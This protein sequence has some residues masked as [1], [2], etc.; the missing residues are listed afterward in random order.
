MNRT[1]NYQI[2]EKNEAIRDFLQ[3]KGYSRHIRTWIKQ[4][5]DSLILNGTPVL[6]YVELHQGDQLAVH[7]KEEESSEKIIPTPLPLHIVYEDEDILIINKEADTPVHPSMGNYEN[8]LA[9]AVAW[10]YA[11]QNKSF[12][13]R[14]INRLDRDT[15]GLLILAKNMLSGALLS[16]QMKQ[17]E[18]HRTYLSIVEGKIPEEG[19][20]S[21]PIARTCDSLIER[22]V[23]WEKGEYAVT[24]YKRLSSL[25]H[26]PVALASD[27][28]K[29]GLSLV[30]LQLE[31]GRTHQ[32]RVHMSYLGHPLI[33]DT[34]Y[35]P[36]TRLMKRQALHSYSLEFIHPITGKEMYFTAPLPPDMDLFF[37]S[38]IIFEKTDK[39]DYNNTII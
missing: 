13:F 5:P 32:I 30:Q 3:K 18:I 7:L 24:H 31:T 26:V 16:Q 10:Y 14:C 19:T 6:S 2:T 38:N 1:F 34:L 11:S 21:A 29:E 27:L 12:V 33:G 39:R 20:I 36:S 22:Q 23:D 37:K 17:R 8:T 25:P 15:T 9:N 4:H 35:N 28:P